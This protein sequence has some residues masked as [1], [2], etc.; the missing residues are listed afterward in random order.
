MLSR[1]R[2]SAWRQTA[3]SLCDMESQNHF[4]GHSAALAAYLKRQRPRHINGLVQ[5]GWTAVSPINSHFRDFPN[6]GLHGDRRRLLVWSHGSRAWSPEEDAH[7]TTPIGAQFVYLAAASGPTPEPRSM[8][9]EVVLMPGHGIQTQRIRGDHEGLAR[10][11]REEEGPSTACLYAA[12]ASD[13]DIVHAYRS[14]GH[15]V[16]VLGERMDPQFLWRLWTML[17]RAKRVVSNRLSTPILYAAHLGADIAIYGDALRLDGEDADE[18][19][20]VRERWPELHGLKIDQAVARAI[21]DRELGAQYL[22]AP[23]ALSHVLGWDRQT[24]VTAVEYWSLSPARRAVINIQ[25]RRNAVSPA[26]PSDTGH[27]MSFA[28]WLRAATS[29]LPQ[30]LPTAI[31]R[32]GETHEPFE[33]LTGAP[34]S[35]TEAR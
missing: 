32:A 3:G 31:P 9:E 17:G 33:V 19:D 24:A 30:R 2:V 25:R 20:R 13:P 15:R 35:S 4:Y 6:L 34:S 22:L 14:A 5:H 12:D 23:D 29:Y 18:M 11:W 8:E 10:Q 27:H 21:C 7:V 16:V 26:A 1:Q 28:A